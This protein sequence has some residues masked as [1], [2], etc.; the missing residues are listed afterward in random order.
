VE[1]QLR[2]H[3]QR[4]YVVP[5]TVSC[6]RKRDVVASVGRSLD[7]SRSVFVFVFHVPDVLNLQREC[8]GDFF[9][10]NKPRGLLEDFMRHS[11]PYSY[12]ASPIDDCSIASSS[13]VQVG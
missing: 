6:A 8:A 4:S 7:L 3:T 10:E 2:C 5:S 13:G 9:M 12:V 1:L 11:V